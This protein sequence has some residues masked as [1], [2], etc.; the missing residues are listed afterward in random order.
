MAKYLNERQI[1]FDTNLIGFPN[2]GD[3]LGAVLQNDGGLFGFHIYGL[4]GTMDAEFARFIQNS[5]GFHGNSSHLYGSCYWPR[6]YGGGDGKANWTAEMT[7]LAQAIG[8]HGPV[9][10]FDTSSGTGIKTTETTY[11]E[12]RLGGSGSCS[13]YYKRMSKVTTTD[14]VV[15]AGPDLKLIRKDM[16]AMKAAGLGHYDAPIYASYDLPGGLAT[17]STDVVATKSNKGELHL[18]KP[19]KLVTF[20]QP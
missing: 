9:S 10:G 6:R 4:G 18:V 3:C 14:A 15:P 17:T 7:A 2:L 1:G 19:S 20:N 12:Y 5:V 16:P 8:Y 11:L 13:I